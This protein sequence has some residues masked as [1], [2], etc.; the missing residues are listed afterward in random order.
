MMESRYYPNSIQDKSSMPDAVCQQIRSYV[1]WLPIHPEL[2]NVSRVYLAQGVAVGAVNYIAPAPFC[3]S[4]K[5]YN[6]WIPSESQ[7]PMQSKK[8]G[9]RERSSASPKLLT[10]REDDENYEDSDGQLVLSLAGDSQLVDQQMSQCMVYV[11][12][13]VLLH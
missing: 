2:N 12:K 10:L 1:D 9:R 6:Q 13:H 3:C 4:R 8:G 7:K 5:L 11:D